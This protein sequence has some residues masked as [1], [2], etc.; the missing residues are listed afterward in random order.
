MDLAL[1][2]LIFLAFFLVGDKVCRSWP[3]SF[4]GPTEAFVFC[5]SLGLIIV[6]FL[7]LL[8]AFL[9]WITPATLWIL[10]GSIYL[11]F[12]KRWTGFLKNFPEWWSS[13]A[14]R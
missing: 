10:L 7:I 6:S 5:S 4:S 12:M 8:L 1:L 14:I 3:L 11:C 9:H 13:L 2:F